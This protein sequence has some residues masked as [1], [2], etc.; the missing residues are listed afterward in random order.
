MTVPNLLIWLWRRIS[1]FCHQPENICLHVFIPT[2]VMDVMWRRDGWSFRFS[3]EGQCVPQTCIILFRKQE[4]PASLYCP[5]CPIE[6][7]DLSLLNCSGIL[8]GWSTNQIQNGIFSSI[9][10]LDFYPE[11]T[12]RFQIVSLKTNECVHLFVPPMV[13][14][15]AQCHA[16]GHYFWA[17]VDGQKT[18]RLLAPVTGSLAS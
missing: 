15:V 2:T 11:P 16:R 14:P 6:S 10:G 13:S 9:N 3:A 12:S 8:C 5:F 4:P 7:N 17:P 1:D 18:S